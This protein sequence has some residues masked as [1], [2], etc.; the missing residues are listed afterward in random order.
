MSYVQGDSLSLFSDIFPLGKEEL[1][2]EGGW[3]PLLLALL[4]EYNNPQSPWR[5][6]LD[7][8]PDFSELDLPMFW[9]R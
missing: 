4:Y 5:P 7:L 9:S 3:V 1:Q 8:I 6:Y 2:C